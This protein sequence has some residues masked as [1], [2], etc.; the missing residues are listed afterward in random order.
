VVGDATFQALLETAQAD[1][2]AWHRE[3]HAT[4]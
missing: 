4:C 2:E 1:S 3:Y